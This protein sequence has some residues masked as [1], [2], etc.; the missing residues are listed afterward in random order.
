MEVTINQVILHLLD[1]GASEPMLSDRPMEMDADLF[2]YFTA[3]LEKAFASDEVKNCRFLPDSAFAAE[4]AHNNDFVDISR[5]IAGVIFEQML[6]YPTIP[7]GD[8]A[9]VDFN[10]GAVPHYGVLKLNYRPGYTHN[11]QVL[12]N[13]Q[14]SSMVPQRTLLP[15]TPKAD[16]A[17][18][19]D[20]ANGVVRLIEKK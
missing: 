1:P 2:E 20:R 3:V 17:A 16:E 14:V 13:G 12:G 19:I 9:V 11:T 10:Y 18:L 5:R 8:L 4:M 7:A 6:Q 15:G